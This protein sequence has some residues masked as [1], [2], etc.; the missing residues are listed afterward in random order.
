MSQQ[1]I[2]SIK[3]E[4]ARAVQAQTAAVT[5]IV[6]LRG[7]TVDTTG[8]AQAAQALADANA[9]LEAALGAEVPPGGGGEPP[10]AT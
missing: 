6:Q 8:L 9:A 5:I 1:I 2:D 10:P 4:I 7:A 3:T